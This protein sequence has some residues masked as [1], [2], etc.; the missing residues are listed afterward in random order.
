MQWRCPRAKPKS[1]P[2]CRSPRP[3]AKGRLRQTPRHRIRNRRLGLKS[4]LVPTCGMVSLGEEVLHYELNIICWSTSSVSF[5]VPLMVI[6]ALFTV[7]GGYS[8]CREDLGWLGWWYVY[9]FACHKWILLT[10]P[11]Q[12]LA[13]FCES[14][15]DFEKIGPWIT[16]KLDDFC[17]P[18]MVFDYTR[19]FR[20]PFFSSVFCH[21]S[22]ACW[23]LFT[24][25]IWTGMQLVTILRVACG[26][27][28]SP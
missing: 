2:W 13:D 14:K 12:K 5:V 15:M 21:V 8:H 6:H 3:L 18:K 11:L 10:V 24:P 7:K 22:F 28:P 4:R 23:G 1:H 27:I 9:F 20:T 17:G 25:R 19:A 26:V 16:L